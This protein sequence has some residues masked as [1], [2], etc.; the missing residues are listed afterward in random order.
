VGI[1]YYATCETNYEII[2]R[3]VKDIRSMHKDVLALGYYDRRALPATRFAKLGLD[4]FTR[5]AVNWSMVPSHPV[6]THFIHNGFDILIN[7]HIERCFPL[8]YIAARTQARF[9]IGKWDRRNAPICDLMIQ[10]GDDVSFG[11]FVDQVMHY[12]NMI[13]HDK[14]Q[15]A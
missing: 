9:K 3:L 11:P 8:K 14:H 4:F 15:E 10:A 5:K 13:N 6:V 1:V 12:L 2:K 7:L